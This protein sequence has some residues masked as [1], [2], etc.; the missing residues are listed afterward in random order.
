MRKTF[1]IAKRNIIEMF[2]DPVS[3]VL[4]IAFPLFM[5]LLMQ[6]LFKS[7][8]STPDNFQIQN[9]A[10]GICVFGY[11]FISLYIS[12]Q[13]ATDKNTSFIKRLDISPIHRY[14]YLFSYYISSFPMILLQTTLFF[15][16]ALAFGFPFNLNLL[17]SIIYLIPSAILYITFGIFIGV[18]S[19]NE[20][21]TGPISSILIS[22][23]GIFG[24]IFMPATAF[25]GT[26]GTIVNLL[27]FSH[28]VAIATDLQ[29]IGASCIYPH[30]LYILFYIVILLSITLIIDNKLSKHK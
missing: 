20:K 15:V 21:V 10:S 18:I 23:I 19:K 1:V 30:I 6:I 8:P 3:L 14:N 12:M 24:G 9:Y 27:P 29:T 13:I 17:L 4:C 16:V 22:V 25:S 2:R 5:L 7:I 28:S 11:T 26:F